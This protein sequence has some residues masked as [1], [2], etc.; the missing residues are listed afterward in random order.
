MDIRQNQRGRFLKITMLVASNKTFVAIPG[1]SLSDF[2]RDVEEVLE[3]VEDEES[4][5]GGGG[6]GGGGASSSGG[7]GR[8]RAQ[9]PREQRSPPQTVEKVLPSKEVRAGGKKFYFDVEQN[10]RG[11]FIK[12]SEV[13]KLSRDMLLACK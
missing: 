6:G 4:P 9:R 10:D 5:D 7:G 8:P 12:L 2:R 11:V 13:N 3:A 1:E